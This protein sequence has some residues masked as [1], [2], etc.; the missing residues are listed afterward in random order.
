MWARVEVFFNTFISKKFFFLLETTVSNRLLLV[1][2][3]VSA[4]AKSP[5]CFFLTFLFFT[6]HVRHFKHIFRFQSFQGRFFV[7][8]WG[9]S[10][11][12]SFFKILLLSV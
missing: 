1:L 11:Y 3:V 6:P 9:I 8:S 2:G 12:F 5:F 7:C 4:R 10:G